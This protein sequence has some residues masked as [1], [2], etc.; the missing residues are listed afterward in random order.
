MSHLKQ[1]KIAHIFRIYNLEPEMDNKTMLLWLTVSNLLFEPEP[2]LALI[3]D[4]SSDG[5]ARVEQ[6]PGSKPEPRGGLPARGPTQLDPAFQ[7][8]IDS[9]EQATAECLGV[10]T[11]K[12][13]KIKK[14]KINHKS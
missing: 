9:L 2:D 1:Y 14:R 6:V 12:P 13:N 10:I 7:L 5:G 11:S 4:F 3:I 8:L